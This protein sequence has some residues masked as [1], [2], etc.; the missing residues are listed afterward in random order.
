MFIDAPATCAVAE[1]VD[2]GLRRG[3]GP[4]AIVAGHENI[5]LAESYDIGKRISCGVTEE[6]EVAIKAPTSCTVSEVI[7]GDVDGI[8]GGIAVISGDEDTTISESYD[9]ASADTSNIS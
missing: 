4:V 6:T 9:V 7:D 8:K 5:V 2:D 1:V 3:E